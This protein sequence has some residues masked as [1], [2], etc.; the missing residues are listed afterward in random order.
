MY[1]YCLFIHLNPYDFV[2]I[3]ISEFINMFMHVYI[4]INY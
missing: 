3:Y 4:Y 1:I 2:N